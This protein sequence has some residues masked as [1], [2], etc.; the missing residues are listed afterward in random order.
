MSAIGILV[1]GKSVALAL[2]PIR[3][4]RIWSFQHSPHWY[5]RMVRTVVATPE[6]ATTIA[7]YGLAFGIALA[8][9]AQRI[10]PGARLM[11]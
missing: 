6:R 4:V 1:I 10:V 5:R 7:A 2:D 8:A 9:T 3:Y 11:R